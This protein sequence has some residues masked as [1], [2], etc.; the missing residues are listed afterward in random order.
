[1]TDSRSTSI[2]KV[3]PKAEDKGKDIVKDF[4][5]YHTLDINSA[6]GLLF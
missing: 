2:T 1:M 4:L 3:T 5:K 6:E